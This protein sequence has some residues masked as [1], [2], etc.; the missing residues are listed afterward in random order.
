MVEIQ[1]R[2][3]FPLW[4]TEVC[5]FKEKKIACSAARGVRTDSWAMRRGLLGV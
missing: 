2:H 1:I 4:D 3:I 5:L